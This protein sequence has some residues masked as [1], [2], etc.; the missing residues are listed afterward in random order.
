M[1][2]MGCPAPA[3][4]AEFATG[5]LSRAALA[6]IS[7]H[8]EG[9]A[10]CAAVLSRFDDLTDSFLAS[11]RQSA[12]HEKATA[13]YVPPELVEAARMARPPRS[14]EAGPHRLDGFELLQELGAG[15]FGQVFR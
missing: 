2:S 10:A 4:L 5:D 15:S 13:A 3:E 14:P 9:C 8:L 7:D 1:H 11:L 6:R 12:E